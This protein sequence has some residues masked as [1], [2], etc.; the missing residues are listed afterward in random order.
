MIAIRFARPKDA[1]EIVAMVRELAEYEKEPAH[2]VKLTEDDLLRD[3]FTEPKRFEC[4]VAEGADGQLVGFALFF[5]NYSTWEGRAGIYVEDLF[6]RDAARGLGLGRKLM[7]QIARIA[8]ERGCVRIDLWVLHWNPA[9]DFYHGL[10]LE[11][12]EEWLPYRMRADAIA[13]LAQEGA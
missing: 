13:R 10:G 8:Q 7:A 1:S 5:H 11:H 4:L 2:S 6:V 9:R 3:G 12:L